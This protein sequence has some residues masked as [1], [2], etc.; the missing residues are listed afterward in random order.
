METDAHELILAEGLACETYLDNP[1]RAAFV[2]GHE[3]AD[4]P[5]IREMPLPR[6]VAPRM[7]PSALRSRLA[8]RSRRW[9]ARRTA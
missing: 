5:K 4:A 1:G 9:L 6:I 7:V 2:N 3:R 8:A